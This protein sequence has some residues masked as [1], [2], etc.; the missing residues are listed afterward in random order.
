MSQL[1]LPATHWHE[2]PTALNAPGIARLF[3]HFDDATAR[4]TLTSGTASENGRIEQVADGVYTLVHLVDADPAAPTKRVARRRAS[5][6]LPLT[7]F[8]Y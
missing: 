1:A 7:T 5:A 3:W 8:V 2:P 6:T 4:W